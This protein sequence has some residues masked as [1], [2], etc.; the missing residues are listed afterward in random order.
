MNIEFHYY[1]IHYLALKAGLPEKEA[2]TIAYSSQFVDNNLLSYTIDTGREHYRGMISQ[3]YGWWD[4]RFPEEIYLPFHFF[5]SFD[6]SGGRRRRDGGKNPLSVRP[7]SQPVKELLIHALKTRNP[8]R[9]GI[10]LHTFADSWSHQ[11]FSGLREEWNRTSDS[12]IIP[13]IGHAQV[14]TQPDLLEK[15]WT[16]SRLSGPEASVHNRERFCEAAEKIYKYLC[17]YNRRP[18]TDSTL[19]IDF[20][21]GLWGPPGNEKPMKERI[22][23]IIIDEN[24]EEYNRNTWKQEAFI[25]ERS[26]YEEES[27]SGYDKLI[28]LKDA[29]VYRDS[30]IVKKP[31]K[32]REGFYSSHFYRW[33]EAAREH[34][35]AARKIIRRY[36]GK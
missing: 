11:N 33:N 31:R 17:T 27:S 24:I 30:R 22:Y 6:V 29:I 5:P 13:P 2:W 21:T 23:D 14:L 1:I 16:D 12:K 35:K 7:N 34:Q 4:T 10:A 15:T 9:I 26:Q 3:N 8:Y 25:Q 19:I 20:L 36:S 28:W 18:F 32:A